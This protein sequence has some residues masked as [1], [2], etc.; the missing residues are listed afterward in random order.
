MIRTRGNQVWGFPQV[1]K[2]VPSN[3]K[4]VP[5]YFMI[6]SCVRTDMYHGHCLS[7]K[8]FKH[9]FVFKAEISD[10][11]FGQSVVEE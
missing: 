5:L 8:S 6:I 2:D 1:S 3:A 9:P 11:N 4:D 10:G 7:G